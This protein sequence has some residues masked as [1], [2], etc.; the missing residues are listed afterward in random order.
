MV[1]V[2]RVGQAINWIRKPFLT[3]K[4]GFTHDPT[5]TSNS[6][7][8][9]LVDQSHLL[10][11]IVG[12]H[13]KA[14]IIPFADMVAKMDTRRCLIISS[15]VL[16]LAGLPGCGSSESDESIDVGPAANEVPVAII[17]GTA[18]WS[19]D[20]VPMMM[21]AAGGR[22]LAELA[23]DRRIE[24]ELERAGKALTD[25]DIEAEKHH[26][27]K[28]PSLVSSLN[29]GSDQSAFVT[30]SD[31]D[32]AH[33]LFR[34]IRRRNR[35]GKHRFRI[36][37]R[38]NAGLR[39][40]IADDVQVNDIL[41][42]QAYRTQYGK[43]VVLRVITVDSLRKA[44][45]VLDRVRRGESFAL[46]AMEMTQSLESRDRGGLLPPVSSDDPGLPKAIQDAAKDIKAGQVS[47]PIVMSN[48]FAVIKC[49]REIPASDVKLE[50]VKD[51]L[52]VAV[53]RGLEQSLMQRRARLLLEATGVTILNGTLHE[54]WDQQR[55]ELLELN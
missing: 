14:D 24:L 39:K 11:N 55:E 16:G 32:Q 54:A 53:R 34:E 38:R 27:I 30:E 44:N 42:R 18:V 25:A 36:L 21:E 22:V 40:L 17:D 28:R 15:V 4:V 19:E 46:V 8:L 9:Q 48:G 23:L 12:P 26:L 31:E 51:K 1:G 20:L 41:V 35:L 50:N 45:T 29:N 5:Q 10:A 6:A 13:S 47:S 43:K 2:E 33:R 3:D 52:E 49:E 7:T 37:L